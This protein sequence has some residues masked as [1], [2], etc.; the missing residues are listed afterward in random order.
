MRRVAFAAFAAM[1]FAAAPAFAGPYTFAGVTF[2]QDSTPDVLAF[3]PS[4]SVVAG[5][6]F[7]AN[8]VTHITGSVAFVASSI[9]GGGVITPQPGF[10]PALSLGRQGFAQLGIDQNGGPPT[11]DANNCHYACAINM[12]TGNNGT[13]TRNGIQVGWTGGRTLGNGSGA[14]FVIYE[15]GSPNAPE[16]FMVR[17]GNSSTGNFS[18]WRFEANDGFGLYLNEGVSG[19]RA[20]AT[21]FDLTDFGIGAGGEI[22]VIQ[23]ANLI[24][25]D[26]LSAGAVKFDG[27]GS[28]HGFASGALDP[29]PLYIGVLHALN[30]PAAVD[31]PSA[32]AAFGV[33]LAALGLIRR[34]RQ[35]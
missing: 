26:T 33:G 13:T 25:T 18:G 2:E 15:S 7:S 23:I 29:D 11:S 30:A 4:N 8:K 27:S 5:A 6:T 1:S 12:P 22:D 34:R 21:V 28:G 3:I 35:D 17:V 19:E 20:F 24:A 14:D 16:G 9:G 10:N 31:A 32:L